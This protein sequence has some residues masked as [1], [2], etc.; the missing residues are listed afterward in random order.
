M[1]LIY[2]Y[3]CTCMYMYNY[4]YYIV[5]IVEQVK[6]NARV[7]DYAYILVYKRFGKSFSAI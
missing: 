2:M 6:M 7:R 5:Y 3:M 4:V 1:D